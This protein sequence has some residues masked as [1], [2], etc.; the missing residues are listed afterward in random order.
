LRHPISRELRLYTNSK[1][2]RNSDVNFF[3]V[4][5]LV[6]KVGHRARHATNAVITAAREPSALNM[7]TKQRCSPRS[8][9]S[10]LV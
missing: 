6:S 3:H 10:K 4:L 7:M 5:G 9:W 1:R 2:K 8:K